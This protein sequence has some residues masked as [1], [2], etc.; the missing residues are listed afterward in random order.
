MW[1]RNRGIVVVMDV[2]F[3]DGGPGPSPAKVACVAD[4]RAEGC[5]RADC[6]VCQRTKKKNRKSRSIC[7]S[8]AACTREKFSNVIVCTVAKAQYD[9]GQKEE[10]VEAMMRGSL[11]TSKLL[12]VCK[13]VQA[14][15]RRGRKVGTLYDG[16]WSY[17]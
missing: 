10:L 6:H 1:P 17:W 4:W 16:R 13:A 3:G 7:L 14:H 9:T 12:T 2:S 11:E 15:W 5:R 8:R